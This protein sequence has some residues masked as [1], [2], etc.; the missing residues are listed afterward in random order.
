MQQQARSKSNQH[1]CTFMSLTVI[2]I[3]EIPYGPM[4]A[5]A[6]DVGTVVLPSCADLVPTGVIAIKSSQRS[7]AYVAILW[8]PGRTPHTLGRENGFL[9]HR[10]AI[11][12]PLLFFRAAYWKPCT[13]RSTYQLSPTDVRIVAKYVLRNCSVLTQS[14]RNGTTDTVP[15]RNQ[16]RQELQYLLT[17]KG[18]VCD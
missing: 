10:V 9:A 5:R 18:D 17:S 8:Y 7:R 12:F 13:A 3:F 15:L 4:M 6:S 14:F 16:T 11:N 2:L 1:A